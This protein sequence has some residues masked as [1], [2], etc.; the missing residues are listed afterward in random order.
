MK[1]NKSL[2]DASNGLAGARLVERWSLVKQV[3]SRS[4]NKRRRKERKG[5]GEC[6][7]IFNLTFKLSCLKIYFTG[8]IL[9]TF[10]CRRT[11]ETLP[12]IHSLVKSFWQGYFQLWHIVG[13]TPSSA[14]SWHH[15]PIRLPRKLSSFNALV[16]MITLLHFYFHMITGPIMIS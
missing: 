4:R 5:G 9:A 11:F 14:D 10:K 16:V 15:W 8:Y 3:D 7:H 13:G 12:N 2:P 6:F 1:N